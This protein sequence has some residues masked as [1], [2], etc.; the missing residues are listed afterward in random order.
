MNCYDIL[1]PHQL[2]ARGVFCNNWPKQII[3]IPAGTY[4]VRKIRGVFSQEEQ[5]EEPITTP[6]SAKGK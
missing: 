1:Q 4:V 6:C 5:P 3:F 2:C